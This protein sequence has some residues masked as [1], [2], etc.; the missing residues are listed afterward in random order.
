[1]S[2]IGRLTALLLARDQLGHDL[3][4]NYKGDAKFNTKLGGFLSIAMQT[5]VL[6]YLIMRSSDLITMAEPAV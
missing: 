2:G 4:I 6:V 1:M 3:S 5:L